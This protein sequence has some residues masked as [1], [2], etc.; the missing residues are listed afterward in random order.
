MKKKFSLLLFIALIQ[1]GYAQTVYIPDPIFKA[2]ILSVVPDPNNDGEIQV[3]EANSW[4]GSFNCT[5]MSITDVTG[6][7]AFTYLSVLNASGN[8]IVSADLSQNIILSSVLLDNN[9][10]TYLNVANGFNSNFNQF[11]TLNNPN[12]SCIE[13]DDVSYSTTNW[14]NIDNGVSFSLGCPCNINVYIPDPNFKNFLL[15]NSAI[16]TNGDTEIQCSEA[17]SFTGNLDC[18][19]MGISDLTGIEAFVSIPRLYCNHNSLTSLDISG[20]TA[21]TEVFCQFNSLTSL[22]VGAALTS[23]YCSDNSLT[24]VDLTQ[25]PALFFFNLNNNQLSALDVSQNTAL[26]E[27]YCND[28]Q[29]SALDVSQNTAMTKLYCGGNSLTAL[30]VTNN[31]TLTKLFCRNNSLSVINLS[32]NTVLEDLWCGNNSLTALDVSANTSLNSIDCQSA[33]ITTLDVSNNTSLTKLLCAS[34]S[35]ESIDI[36]QNPNIIEFNCGL[37]NMLNTLNVANGN[38]NNFTSFNAQLTANLS[39]IQVDDVTWSTANWSTNVDAG[40]SFSTNCT[41]VVLVNSIV[42][43]GQ[44]GASTISTPGGSLQM[45]ATVLP[46]NADDLTYTWSVLNGTG[47]ATINNSGLLTASGDGIVTVVATANDASGVSNGTQISISNQ[48]LGINN[49]ENKIGF[50]VF[51]NPVQDELHIETNN[52]EL[53]KIDI[54][55]FTGK[56]IHKISNESSNVDVSFLEKGVYI[57]R[58]HSASGIVSQRFIKQ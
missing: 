9:E 28:N 46:A 14:T 7:E 56:V 31:T 33:Q 5:N 49:V 52:M 48:S 4:S 57:L 3:S 11:N 27:V 18:Q 50:K 1:F 22:N 34:N 53:R 24:S 47:S 25:C 37:N 13:V 42:V 35:I 2:Y 21:L 38:N 10:L 26:L 55:D 12:L 45:E 54:T 36:S 20:N 19:N 6:V 15:G 29:L 44:G 30:D 39:C 43:Q 16:N 51:P 32:Q 58:V 17:S 41:G 23:L 8:S 40:V